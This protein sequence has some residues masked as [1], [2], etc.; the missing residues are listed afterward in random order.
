[1]KE[2]LDI[3]YNIQTLF[4]SRDYEEF[5]ELISRGVLEILNNDIFLI[6]EMNNKGIMFDTKN[7]LNPFKG[8]PLVL[9]ISLEG[10]KEINEELEKFLFQKIVFS[11]KSNIINF[12]LL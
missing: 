9:S 5:H 4:G 8:K 12:L 10:N 1:M 7:F 3:N 2:G 6:K 11:I